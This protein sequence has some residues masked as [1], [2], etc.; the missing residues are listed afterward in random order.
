MRSAFLCGMCG[1]ACG[2][3]CAINPL[4]SKTVRHVRHCSLVWA[5][6]RTP[7]PA[8]ARMRTRAGI[9]HMTH[10]AHSRGL[11]AARHAAHVPAQS[12]ARAFSHLLRFRKKLVVVA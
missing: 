7:A 5:R 10:M 9:T 8:G 6:A 12:R 2:I 1:M 4:I 11:R 3:P